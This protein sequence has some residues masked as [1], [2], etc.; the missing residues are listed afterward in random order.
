M[1]DNPRYSW[2][3]SDVAKA[4]PS[5]QPRYLYPEQATTEEREQMTRRMDVDSEAYLRWLEGVGSDPC[6]YTSPSSKDIA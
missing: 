2:H 5:D 6:L 4:G 3:M 1:A